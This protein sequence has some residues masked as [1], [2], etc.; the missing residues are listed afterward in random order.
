MRHKNKS[1]QI[2]SARAAGALKF[3]VPD[4]GEGR[5]RYRNFLPIG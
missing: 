4:Q 3:A 2:Q 5:E 1:V